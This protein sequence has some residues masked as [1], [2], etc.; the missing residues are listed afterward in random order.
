[1]NGRIRK[2]LMSTPLLLNLMGLQSAPAMAANRKAYGGRLELSLGG[3]VTSIDPAQLT[4]VQELELARQVHDT[5]FRVA[6]DGTIVPSLAQELPR[7]STG[8]KH[9]VIHLRPGAIFHDGTA[10]TSTEVLATWQ[11]LLKPQ[12]RS[13]HWWLLAVVEGAMAFRQ[14]KSKRISG[15]ERIN[16]LS[17]RI[18]LVAPIPAFLQVLSAVPTAPLPGRL[19]AGKLSD[20]EVL[21]GSGP[22]TIASLGSGSETLRLQAFVG[23]G[24]GRP[25]LDQ[26]LYYAFPSTHAARLA[27]EV[28]KIHLTDLPARSAGKQ[29]S[30]YTG[31]QCRMTFLVLNQD[32]LRQV[33]EGFRH[34][35]DQA[36]DRK[37]LVHYLIGKEGRA[38]DEMIVLE[39]ADT[40]RQAPTADPVSA[41]QFFSAFYSQR[42]AAQSA[43]LFL[44]PA[45]QSLLRAIA[46]RIQLNLV[47]VGARVSV[48]SLSRE[49]YQQRVAAGDYDFILGQPLPLVRDPYLQLLG[50]VATAVGDQATEEVLQISKDLPQDANR[51]AVVREMAR[52][53]QLRLPRLPLFQFG[54][55]VFYQESVRDYVQGPTGLTDL[56]EVW[57]SK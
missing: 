27:F 4:T 2:L 44:V 31:R 16:K 9:W 24:Q 29:H 18:R 36:V 5:L 57:L 32:R 54:R 17:F 7:V 30:S 35:V 50:L 34:A 40:V 10:I 6:A 14:G 42:S 25:F 12:T 19:L 37:S 1:M 22:F 56:A 26:V 8:G 3:P 41:K 20:P 47:D 39:P 15:L 21:S 28:E 43:L 23:H 11:R 33:P 13:P 49:S 52:R 46:E 45:E 53:Y 51:D 48:Q 55:R 38:T